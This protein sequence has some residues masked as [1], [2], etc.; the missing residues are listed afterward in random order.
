MAGN[1]LGQAAPSWVQRSGARGQAIVSQ[2]PAP[3][4]SAGPHLWP[5]L[6]PPGEVRPQAAPL[7]G[8]PHRAV[9]AAGQARAEGLAHDV[10]ESQL[11]Q[12][13]GAP[14]KA[15][16]ACKRSRRP[17]LGDTACG[18]GARRRRR[19]LLELLLPLP[20]ALPLGHRPHAVGGQG[21]GVGHGGPGQ[22]QAVPVAGIVL[23]AGRLGPRPARQSQG[24]PQGGVGGHRPQVRVLWRARRKGVWQAGRLAVGKRRGGCRRGAGTRTAWRA[25]LQAWIACMRG[26]TAC[27][28]EPHLHRDGC[29]VFSREVAAEVGRGGSR[30]VGRRGRGR[31][32]PAPRPAPRLPLRNSAVLQCALT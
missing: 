1:S 16:A 31:A 26:G 28:S 17:G 27:S 4:P 15:T 13:A 12:S 18:A 24:A 23:R 10:L 9:P 20:L 21:E 2:W 6:C 19:R 3:L 14:A 22:E 25:P 11:R 29:Q 30:V 32:P 7:G 8:A 5:R